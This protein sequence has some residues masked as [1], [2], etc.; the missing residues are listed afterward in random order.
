M[1]ADAAIAAARAFFDAFNAQHHERVAQAFNY[2]HIRHARSFAR[3]ESAGE[4][5]LQSRRGEAQLAKEGW[6]HSELERIEVLQGDDD[7]KKVHLALTVA[8]CRE[9]GTVYNRFET[10]WIAT[11]QDGHWGI[12]FRSSFLGTANRA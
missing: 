11:C 2:P 1:S 10:L 7:S 12:Q 8:R 6:H 9:D 4:F 5:L 3:T